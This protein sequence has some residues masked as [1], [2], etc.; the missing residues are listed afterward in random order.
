M[1][2]CRG[3]YRIGT[4][5][6]GR[7]TIIIDRKPSEIPIHLDMMMMQL[8]GTSL[9]PEARRT[10]VRLGL[11]QPIRASLDGPNNR[12]TYEFLLPDKKESAERYLKHSMWVKDPKAI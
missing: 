6:R 4:S 8:G 11:V 7:P 2:C 3:C 5:E 12:V 9:M 10:D 1:N